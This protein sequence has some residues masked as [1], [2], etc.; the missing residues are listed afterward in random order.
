[1]I[2]LSL[3]CTLPTSSN[4]KKSE[5]NLSLSSV[6]QVT[7]RYSDQITDKGRAL[8]KRRGCQKYTGAHEEK[9]G[10]L[11]SN[12]A[13]KCDFSVEAFQL[14][15]LLIERLTETSKLE[16]C[17]DKH[18]FSSTTAARKTLESQCLLEL[19]N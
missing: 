18:L 13:S 7:R 19:S 8:N 2:E 3:E 16:Q 11:G 14:K 10:A 5:I 17:T 1:M 12:V 15:I 9:P 6:I 4:A